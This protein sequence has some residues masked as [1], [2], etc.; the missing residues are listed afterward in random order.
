MFGAVGMGLEVAQSGHTVSLPT[1]GTRGRR[2]D[3]SPHPLDPGES[4]RSAGKDADR[5][6][7]PERSQGGVR[8]AAIAM[9]LG[10]VDREKTIAIGG[11]SCLKT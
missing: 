3:G 9:F 6:P 1:A 7:H 11:Q 8:E 4:A 2:I 5:H 10:T